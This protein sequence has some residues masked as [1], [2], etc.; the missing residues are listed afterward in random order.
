MPK[1]VILSR[2][3]HAGRPVRGRRLR[4]APRRPGGR[5]GPGGGRPCWRAGRGDR[6]RLA[7][8]R[9]P[10]GRGQPRCRAHG[11]SPRRAAG[12]GGRCHRQ[13]SV[14][15]RARRDRGRLSCRDRGRWRPLRGRRCRV[16]VARAARHGEARCCVPT[17]RPHPVRHARSAGASRIREWRR[18]F[19]LETMGETGENVAERWAVSRGGSD[20]FAAP[21]AA[22]GGLRRLRPGRFDDELVSGG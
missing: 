11:G 3:P 7:R 19:L 12:V 6:R 20:A 17:R 2:S 10:G 5:R 13:P 1:A 15:L 8:L 9:E 4:H 21:F 22:S 16:D 18:L 14:C